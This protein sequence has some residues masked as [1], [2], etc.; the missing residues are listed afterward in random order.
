MNGWIDVFLKCN[1]AGLGKRGKGRGRAGRK[2]DEKIKKK[3]SEIKQKLFF[4]VFICIVEIDKKINVVFVLSFKTNGE[5]GK[6]KFM[7]FFSRKKKEIEKKVE[8]NSHSIL[9]FFF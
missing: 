4:V 7:T 8:I 2:V 3:S 1:V 9:F 6:H 5:R